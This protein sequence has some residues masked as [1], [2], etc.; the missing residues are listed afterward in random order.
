MKCKGCL[1]TGMKEF[2][3][4]IS[5]M[6]CEIKPLEKC[7]V[8][9]GKGVVEPLTNEEFIRTASTEELAEFIVGVADHCIMCKECFCEPCWCDEKKVV[10]WL[11]E[12]HT[13]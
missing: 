5:A 11:K 3:V 9:N 6:G 13:E 8:C 4:T 1:G 12:L 10:W 7:E 2:N